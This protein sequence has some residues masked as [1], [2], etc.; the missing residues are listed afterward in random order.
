MLCSMDRSNWGEGPE[1]YWYPEDHRAAAP[2]QGQAPR[3]LKSYFARDRRRA[4]RWSVG[5][6]AA[7][8][9]AGGGAIAGV[10]VADH[11]SQPTNQGSALSAAVNTAA[12]PSPGTA[13]GKSGA[14]KRALGRLR[15]LRG[16]HGEATYKTK[17]GFREISWERG[18]IESVSG[19]D[20]VVRSSDGTTWTWAMAGNTA[21]RDQGKKAS[22]SSLANGDTV[23]V[24]GPESGSTRTARVIVVPKKTTGS[25]SSG[26]SSSSSGT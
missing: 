19:Q 21:V 15:A 23:F 1:R 16:I 6:V 3:D 9:L 10:A 2:P 5:I 25:S 7:A 14:R 11:G 13:G 8:V 24:A 4:M 22:A 20:V 26:S 17:N 18:V 12:S